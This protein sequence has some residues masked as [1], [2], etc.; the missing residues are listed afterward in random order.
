MKSKVT[1]M[2]VTP[3]GYLDINDEY[4]DGITAPRQRFPAAGDLQTRYVGHGTARHVLARNPFGI[5]QARGTWV[6]RHG[7]L[8][9]KEAAGNVGGVNC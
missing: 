8:G 7:E 3:V 6:H 4:L 2:E 9:V 1:S 5:G